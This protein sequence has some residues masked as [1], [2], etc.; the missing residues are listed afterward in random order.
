VQN[1]EQQPMNDQQKIEAYIQK[2]ADKKD[3]LQKLRAIA[4][5][6]EMQETLKWGIP[7][8]TI[9]GKNVAGIASFKEYAGIWF[10]Q[11]ALLKDE[12]QLLV[13]AQEGKTQAMRQLRFTSVEEIDG[14]LLK[15]YLEEAVANEKAGKKVKIAKKAP[16]QIPALLKDALSQS[17]E[18]N[19][20]Y[21]QLSEAKQREYAEYITEAKREETRLNRLEKVIPMIKAK[22]GL[23]DKYKK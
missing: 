6:T 2:H 7:T 22:K 20:M 23:N 14:Q 15:A 4:L 10:F 1:H 13:N 16:P 8:Y 9:R 19:Q 11:G 18:L 21:F 17:P 5:A 12:H 3:L